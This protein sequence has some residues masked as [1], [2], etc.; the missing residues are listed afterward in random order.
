MFAPRSP[1][2][3]PTSDNIVDSFKATQCDLIFTVPS[4]IEVRTEYDFSEVIAHCY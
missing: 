3:V 2:P 4:M 1:A